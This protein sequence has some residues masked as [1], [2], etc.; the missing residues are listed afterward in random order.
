[1]SD[2]PSLLLDI[3]NTSIKYSWYHFADPIAD[4]QVLRTSPDSLP[5][6][7]DQASACWLCSVV[8][9]DIS[10]TI[11]GLC[12]ERNIAFYQA[13]TLAIQFDVTN[14]Y[15]TPQ[16]M[17]T[18]RWMGIIAGAAMCDKGAQNNF[19]SIDAGTAITC[20]FVAGNK[21][22]GGWIAPGL[23]LARSSVVSNTKRVFD[24]LQSLQHLTLGNDTPQCVANGALAQ[25][26][27]MLHQACKIMRS[28][29]SKFEIY[30]SGGDAPLLI[31]AFLALEHNK[32]GSSINY[33]ENLVLIGLAKIAHESIA[34]ND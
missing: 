33:V 5:D 18:D 20:D 10:E 11:R 31:N 21:H 6:L 13:T 22:L 7:L 2:Q 27:G 34:K 4:L 1:V 16:N 17:G 14:A 19:I 25:L 15:S 26:T 8:N 28:Y 3:G 24:E 12:N 23:A 29:C 32:Q 30:I 9:N